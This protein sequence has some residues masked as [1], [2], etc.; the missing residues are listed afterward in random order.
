MAAGAL[1]RRAVRWA[2]AALDAACRSAALQT[3]RHVVRAIDALAQLRHRAV[4]LQ[5]DRRA[6]GLWPATPARLAAVESRDHDRGVA[7]LGLQHRGELRDQHQLAG[8]YPGV[9]D[10]LSD[11]D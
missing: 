1:P 5:H 9:D 2:P 8:L 7:G 11:T 3:C 4:G 10:E 6:G